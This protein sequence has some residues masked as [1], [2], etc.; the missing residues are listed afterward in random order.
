MYRV[1]V[2][3][4]RDFLDGIHVYESLDLFFDL[5]S[6]EKDFLNTILVS[7]GARGA[8]SLAIDWAKDREVNYHVYPA[9]WK[10]FGRSSGPL[11][12]REMI[13][14]GIDHLIAFP[15]GPGTAD[16]VAACK[17]R[18]IPTLTSKEIL[19]LGLLYK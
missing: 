18:N 8:D 9:K 7:G 1:C 3:G 16:M 15:G 19:D 5:V 10:T 2:T 14:A 4:G 12:N 6:G 11:R 17:K 13:E